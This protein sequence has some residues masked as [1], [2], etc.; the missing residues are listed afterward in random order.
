MRV[1]C[2][3]QEIAVLVWQENPDEEMHIGQS[4]GGQPTGSLVILRDDI[5]SQ[6]GWV[7][8]CTEGCQSGRR[9]S[10]VVQESAFLLVC[11][12]AVTDGVIG[13]GVELSLQPHSLPQ[14]SWL[15]CEAQIYNPLSTQLTHF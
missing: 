10:P 3:N 11:Y 9:T 8:V 13:Q 4:L 2:R 14:R 15:S 5:P 1:T 12:V 6:P 7:A